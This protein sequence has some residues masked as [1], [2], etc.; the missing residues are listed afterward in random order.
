MADEWVTLSVDDG[1]QTRAFVARPS[2]A[3]PHP[4]LIVVMEALG[5]NA[6]IRDVAWRYA[7]QGFLAIAPDMFHRAEENVESDT[8]DWNRLMPLVKSLTM[9]SLISDTRAAY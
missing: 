9:E 7:A 3:G 4:G 8:L 5:V 2:G 6:Q 1:T